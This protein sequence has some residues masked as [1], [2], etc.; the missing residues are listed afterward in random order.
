MTHDLPAWSAWRPGAPNQQLTIGI[1][2]EFM[3][4]DPDDWALA[5]R[6]DKVLEALPADLRERVT[7]ETH[8]AVMEVTTGV[9]L[10]VRDAVNELAGLRRRLTEALAEQGLRAAVAG[11]HPYATS[12]DTVVSS[13]PRYRQIGETMRVLARRE[14][15]L[16]THVHVGVATPAAAVRLLNRFR[17]HLPLLLALSANSPFWQGSETGFASTRTTLWDAFP[18]S[19]VPRRFAGYWDWIESVLPLLRSG[20]IADPSY[21]W[22]D[23][24]LQ[25]K[26]G[27]VEVRIMDGQ[28]TVGDVGALAALVQSLASLELTRPD[29]PDESVEVLEE[30]RFLAA[31]DGMQALLIDVDSGARVPAGAQLKRTLA[32]CHRHARQLE[33]D[34]ELDAIRRLVKRGGA[35]RQL[36]HSVGGDLREVVAGLARAY[37][38]RRAVHALLDNRLRDEPAAV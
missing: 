10:R 4:L 21:L 31:R 33:C 2:E 36:A 7:L 22:W 13:H 3:L 27:T 14:P 35:A 1:E 15:T 16:A 6:S 9:H 17:S 32:L 28:T 12:G 18:R 5:Y 29:A 24:R 26:L 38:P 30:N 20:A 34:R 23:V 19:G 8:A 11:T 25:P 37:S